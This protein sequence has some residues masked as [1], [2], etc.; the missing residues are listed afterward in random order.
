MLKDLKNFAENVVL[1]NLNAHITAVY[2]T[3]ALSKW[4]TIARKYLC[5]I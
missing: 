5:L 4:I 3:V 2:V 1:L